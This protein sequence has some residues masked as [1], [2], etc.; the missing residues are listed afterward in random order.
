MDKH[1]LTVKDVAERLGM[2]T[3]HIRALL[4]AETL[5]GT[6]HGRDWMIS[7]EDFAEFEKSY[8]PTTGR[9]RGSRSVSPASGA[10]KPR[11]AKTKRK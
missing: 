7:A 10:S 9:P 11:K 6:K 4:L 5:R 1:F 2:D 8:K 3:G